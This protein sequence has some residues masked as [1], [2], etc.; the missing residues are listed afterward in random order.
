MVG[1]DSVT[2]FGSMG[3]AKIPSAALSR[4]DSLGQRKTKHA[5]RADTPSSSSLLMS[6]PLSS[7]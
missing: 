5:E 4:K 7:R 6:A 2:G 1:G 3:L